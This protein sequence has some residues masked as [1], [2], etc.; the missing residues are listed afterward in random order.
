MEINMKTIQERI[1]EIDAK[2]LA[3]SKVYQGDI[4][5]SYKE[6][7]QTQDIISFLEKQKFELKQELE[8]GSK[9]AKKFILECLDGEKI[10]FN[11]VSSNP[12]RSN[13]EISIESLI[14]KQLMSSSQNDKIIFKGKEFRIV[15]VE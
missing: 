7:S 14:G 15:G 11:V 6:A 2:I 3:L 13:N 10:T 12:D 1:I 8:K 9:T 4:G 5:A